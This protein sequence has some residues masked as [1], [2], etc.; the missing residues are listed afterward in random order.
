ML[1]LDIRTVFF[2]AIISTA[3][4]AGVMAVLWRQNR[5]HSPEL[6][7]WLAD[8]AMQAVA[9]LLLVLRGE[10][11]DFAS[12]VVSNALVVGGTLIL[13]IGLER[14]VGKRRSHRLNYIFLTAFI[15]V[16]TY[17]TY[18]QPSLQARTLNASLGLFVM[19]FQIAWLMLRRVEPAMR[20][21][22]RPVG[23]IFSVYCLVIVARV[24]ADLTVPLG[25]DLF[26]FG[27]FDTPAILTYQM[28]CIGLTM[29]LL[30]MVNRRLFAELAHEI[31]KLA[32]AH[33][34]LKAS[35][36]KFASA[37]QSIPDA[38]VLTA[39]ADGR[40]IET[41]A[42]FFRI[43]EYAP[44]EIANKTIIELNLWDNLAER[45]RFVEL[46]QSAGRV[47]DFE[48]T[49]RKK[50]GETI[51]TL[52]SGEI[53]QL[54]DG[55]CVLN[56]IRDITELKQAETQRNAR[57]EE[58]RRWQTVTLGREMRVIELKREINGLLTQAGQ[59][60]RYASAE[61]ASHE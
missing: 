11:P 54:P 47:S 45:G 48:T 21:V 20:P 51:T 18:A 10:V 44:A 2:S 4:C 3:I 60:I 38:I 22:V 13:F 37:F 30:L 56:V 33:E 19:C 15:G 43:T 27:I 12:M 14:Y 17:F 36:A 16:H 26:K 7:F 52:I 61:L 58:L 35:E 32:Q 50:S 39:I 57:M 59:P 5:R 31:R 9:M 24:A 49:F 8:F 34:A 1:A 40:I 53:I 55:K 6:G 25:N 29:A 23:V 28:L 41:N 42:S 46:L